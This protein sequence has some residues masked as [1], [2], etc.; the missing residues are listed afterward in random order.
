MKTDQQNMKIVTIEEAL[1]L[2]ASIVKSEEKRYV[3]FHCDS[4][5]TND[6]L[7]KVLGKDGKDDFLLLTG[8]ANEYQAKKAKE[9]NPKAIV[10]YTYGNQDECFQGYKKI[11]EDVDCSLVF[12]AY[13]AGILIGSTTKVIPTDFFGGEE[14]T[15]IN[16]NAMTAVQIA[17]GLEMVKAKDS[18]VLYKSL[19]SYYLAAPQLNGAPILTSNVN[20]AQLQSGLFSVTTVPEMLKFFRQFPHDTRIQI[21]DPEAVIINVEYLGKN[22]VTLEI[23]TLEDMIKKYERFLYT[24]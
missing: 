18:V 16:G 2:C 14:Y 3:V 15:C 24:L 12:L 7:A 9:V 17:D 1:S 20:S 13:Y 4:L 19:E 11:A 8:D 23:E 21:L 22:L 10:A 6:V 5:P